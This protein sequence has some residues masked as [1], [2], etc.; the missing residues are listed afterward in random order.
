MAQPKRIHCDE[1]GFDSDLQLI[2]TRDSGCT[3][4]ASSPLDE[5]Y[6]PSSHVLPLPEPRLWT[7]GTEPSSK[8]HTAAPSKS[9]PVPVNYL[10]KSTS[11][12]YGY[13][14]YLANAKT[15]TS[16]SESSLVSEKSILE[17]PLPRCKIPV[18][19]SRYTPNGEDEDDIN[20]KRVASRHSENGKLSKN[21][22]FMAFFYC[23]FYVRSFPDVLISR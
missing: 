13:K 19:F 14:R 1:S 6:V 12:D 5:K 21:E 7:K 16:S 10:D 8:M 9:I 23:Q 22:N 20:R 4:R 17:T 11:P 3:R 15:Q 18:P 2:P